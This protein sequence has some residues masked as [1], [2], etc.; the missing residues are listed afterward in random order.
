MFLS[1]TIIGELRIGDSEKTGHFFLADSKNEIAGA[2]HIKFNEAGLIVEINNNSGHY[3]PSQDCSNKVVD[4]FKK[5]NFLAPNAV[6]D[7]ENW[8]K[9]GNGYKIN[10]QNQNS[11]RNNIDIDDDDKI[12]FNNH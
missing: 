12:D 5:A 9:V 10:S 8:S 11:G 1:F 2:G 3:K 4:A 7:P 6:H